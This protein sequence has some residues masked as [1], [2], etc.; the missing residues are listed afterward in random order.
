MYNASLAMNSAVNIVSKKMGFNL[1][2]K[3]TGEQLMYRNNI[4]VG[5]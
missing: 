1:K 4:L 2:P 3:I 5:Q